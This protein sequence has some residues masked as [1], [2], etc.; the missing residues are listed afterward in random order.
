MPPRSTILLLGGIAALGSLATQLLVP[1]LPALSRELEVG[2]GPAQLVVGVFLIGLGGGQLLVGPLA[3]RLPRRNLL[4]AGLLLYALSSLLASFAPSLPVL[5]LGRLG[6]AIGAS[7]GLVTA[8]VLLNAMVPPERAVAAQASLMGIVLISPALAPVLGGLLTEWIGWRAILALLCGAGL[9][10][11]A[12]VAWRIPVGLPRARPAQGGLMASYARLLR[13]RRFLAATAAMSC[14]TAALYLFLGA[15]PFLLEHHYHLSPRETGL[16]L[17]VMASASIAGTRIVGPVQR[18]ADPL[19]LSTGAGALA[20]AVLAG[21]AWR[22]DPQLPLLLA[23]LFVLGMTAGLTGPTSIS[24]I[25][26]SEPG[27]EASATSLAGAM[28]MGI[29]ALTAWLLGPFAAGSAWQM[30]VGMLPLLL[31]ALAAATW[32]GRIRQMPR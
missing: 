19:P 23:P 8:R 26:A 25:M 29:S 5:L 20:V 2:I 3:D 15:T 14:G 10:G 16:V 6:Q 7:A 28:Q 11:M 4:L 12:V 32:L 27:L 17:L 9:V 24:H 1:A 31:V 30:A 18:L 13:N 21:L 22:G